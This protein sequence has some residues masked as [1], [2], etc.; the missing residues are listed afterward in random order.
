MDVVSLCRLHGCTYSVSLVMALFDAFLDIMAFTANMAGEWCLAVNSSDASV[1]RS[2]RG[3]YEALLRLEREGAVVVE[4]DMP[5]AHLAL[6][7][8]T[9]LNVWPESSVQVC[10]DVFKV[11]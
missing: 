10:Q 3:L 6:S 11:P 8:S 7:A 9:C 4:R 1:L 2:R 5:A